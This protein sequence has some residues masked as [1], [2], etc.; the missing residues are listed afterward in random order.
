MLKILFKNYLSPGDI[1]AMTGAIRDLK[2]QYPAYEIAMATTCMDIWINNPYLSWFGEADANV[3]VKLDYPEIHN[4]DK[5]GMHFSNAFHRRIED[6]LNIRL[7]Q[8]VIWPDLHLAEKE[9]EERV[10]DGRYWILN[11]G[12]KE[13]FSLK[14]WGTKNYQEVVDSLKGRVKFVQVG[15]DSPG[16]VH[17][18][19]EGAIDLI[20]V[21]SF[22]DYMRLAYHSDGSIGP[23]SMHMHVSA[24]FKKPCVTI[25]GG[26]EP[27]RWEVYPNQRYL[28]TNGQL[29]CCRDSACWKNWLPDMVTEENKIDVERKKENIKDKICINHING[30]EAKCMSM[31]TP[32]IVVR[33]I[34]NYYV[35]GVL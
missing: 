35:G 34:L 9:K 1:V 13:D 7:K 31:I 3:V 17:N 29:S 19:I 28:S 23:V 18:R 8:S 11:A 2:T 15:E 4:S 10:I 12:Y 25:A 26:R 6:L 27:F 5:S 33:E 30:K 24:A 21:T 32:D 22:R 14:H 16:H 20:G